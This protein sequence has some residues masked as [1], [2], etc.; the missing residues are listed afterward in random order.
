MVSSLAAVTAAHTV[1]L[2]DMRTDR[3][4][5]SIDMDMTCVWNVQNQHI[6]GLQKGTMA[7][8]KSGDR[9]WKKPK[10]LLH[11]ERRGSFMF[12]KLLNGWLSKSIWMVYF[13]RVRMVENVHRDKYFFF[14]ILQTSCSYFFI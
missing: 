13:I 11:N 14:F 7:A 3:D 10:H 1:P 8:F 12:V 9:D 4:V 5:T 2:L 6:H